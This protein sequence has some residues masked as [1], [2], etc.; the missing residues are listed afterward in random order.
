MNNENNTN[1]DNI[2]NTNIINI[3]DNNNEVVNNSQEI[4][5]NAPKPVVDLTSN[6]TKDE[7]NKVVSQGYQN[8]NNGFYEKER[9]VWPIILLVVLAGIVGFGC[10][11]YFVLTKPINIIKKSMNNLYE[12]IE[13]LAS[14]EEKEY[15]SISVDSN[16]IITTSDKTSGLNELNPRIKIG[17]D[18]KTNNNYLEAYILDAEKKSVINIKG[19]LIDN[20][21]YLDLKDKYP[22]VV[23]MDVENDSE[24]SVG[25]IELF[26]KEDIDSLT[27]N[28]LYL[29]K[30]GKDGF[31][32]NVSEE[33]LSKKIL[34]KDIYGKK[35]P[36][37]EVK[38][39]IDY[40]EYKKINKGIYDEILNDE[41]AIDAYYNISKLSDKNVTRA[42]A[43]S[44]LEKAKNDIS[45][46]DFPNTEEVTITLD[47]ITNKLIELDIINKDSTI[48]YTS[49]G[50]E[51]NINI[52]MSGLNVD[53]TIDEKENKVFADI[54]DEEL[55]RVSLTL[56]TDLVSDNETKETISLVMYNKEDVN[57]EEFSITGDF[58]I[59]LNDKVESVN[60]ENAININELNKE[61]SEKVGS[62]L[63]PI[64][65]LL[66][67]E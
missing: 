60:K 9:K 18:V 29:L 56:K 41:K 39:T 48:K 33:K 42:S 21:I 8:V 19:S 27:K 28:L 64:F 63:A 37:I 66:S 10:Y 49:G 46:L 55:G 11:Y 20:K 6:S 38:Y 32:K 57:K 67:D 3:V 15:N 54:K 26:K 62:A 4:D 36:A 45:E 22:N 2:T 16:I 17:Y 25:E 44:E 40:P 5:V 51:A 30:V 61:D 14:V 65:A 13:K 24:F 52:V 23:Y 7:N 43:K 12:S 47:M 31:I 50:N 34:L 58:D 53:V 1:K 59:K 35:V